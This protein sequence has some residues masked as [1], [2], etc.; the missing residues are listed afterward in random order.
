[1][2]TAESLAV[3]I[4]LSLALVMPAGFL[5]GFAFP[6]GMALVERIDRAPTPWFWGIN[7]A[8]GVL[9]SVLAVMVSMAFGI[10]VTMLLA[11]TCYLLLIPF[12]R[13]L[14]QTTVRI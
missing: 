11:G 7:G 13:A 9:G 5:M 4:S 12:A 3:R 2:T 8:A 6:T 14:R 1:M 10:N